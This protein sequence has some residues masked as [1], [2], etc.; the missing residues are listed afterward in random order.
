MGK[1][2]EGDPLPAPIF[3]ESAAT[4]RGEASR[5]CF[6]CARVRKLVSFR[7]VFVLVLAFALA[8]SA[9]FCLPFF[10]FGNQMIL[11]LE[12]QG[13][14]IVASF[15]LR[16]PA[17]VLEGQRA[18]LQEDIF[19]EISFSS[20]EVQILSV[21]ASE[22]PNV[23]TVVFAVESDSTTRSL[24]RSSFMSL[25]SG[26]S[27]LHLTASLFGDPISFEVLKFKG[28]ITVSP[29]QKAFLMQSVQ[30]VFNFTL[31]FSVDEILENFDELSSQLKTGLRLA[32]YENLYISLINLKGSTIASPTTVQSEVLLAV[33]INPSESRL[34]QLAQTITAGS[35]SRNLGLNNTVFGRVKQISLS[36]ILQHSLGNEGGAAP[37]PSP[38]S[39]PLASPQRHH[40]HGHN[41]HHDLDAAPSF[42]PL[43]SSSHRRHPTAH[44]PAPAPAHYRRKPWPCHFAGSQRKHKIIA[45]SAA[46]RPHKKSEP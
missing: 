20:T 17:F 9:V 23:T 16:K 8:L 21:E 14:D 35:H 12:Y 44:A 39:S 37:S 30:I 2:D 33:G 41:R 22:E 40:H 13:Y 25:V 29:V 3:G 45:P 15:E 7:C 1:P 5:C 32:P 31:N 38:A 18:Q 19:N 28:G 42:P 6:N 4:R 36:S 46:P 34:K 11:D 10:R 43:P 26:Q 24:I 27:S